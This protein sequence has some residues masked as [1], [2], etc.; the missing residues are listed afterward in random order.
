MNTPE[1]RARVLSEW[2]A[3]DSALEIA[4]RLGLTEGRA[5]GIISYSRGPEAEK[6]NLEH[7]R[8]RKAQA[9]FM[10]RKLSRENIDREVRV[11]SL[12][13]GGASAGE[14]AAKFDVTRNVVIGIVH[15]AR[16]ADAEEAKR[17][18][19]A[20]IGPRQ[21][22]GRTPRPIRLYPKPVT[23]TLISPKTDAKL[24]QVLSP[25][26]LAERKAKNMAVQRAAIARVDLAVISNPV[27][28]KA[29][30]PIDLFQHM[31]SAP[32]FEGPFV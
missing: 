22:N 24:K 4:R 19:A 6:A 18:H 21:P 30:K 5:A 3:G 20:I 25:L 16:G 15:R 23:A 32:P 7:F 12:W 17:A 29:E 2:A 14:I 27:F 10:P 31:R 9:A 28:V 26:A 8:N 13:A 11:L 1:L